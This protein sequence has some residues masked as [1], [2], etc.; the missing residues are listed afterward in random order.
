MKQLDWVTR[1]R[2]VGGRHAPSVLDWLVAAG[3]V[4]VALAEAV[5][6]V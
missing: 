4:V 2:T 3:L 1:E 5:G 6:G